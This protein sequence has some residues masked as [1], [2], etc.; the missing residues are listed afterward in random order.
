MCRPMRGGQSL[1]FDSS[2]ARCLPMP[3]NLQAA[4]APE[5]VAPVVA[6]PTPPSLD[7]VL[8]L[9]AVDAKSAPEAY[10]RETEVPYGGE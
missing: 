9:I 7:E 8:A 6:R 2:G 3:T 10:L 1:K 4:K 5:A